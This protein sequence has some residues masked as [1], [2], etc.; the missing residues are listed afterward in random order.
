LTAP[1]RSLLGNLPR[2]TSLFLPERD[3]SYVFGGPSLLELAER[4]RAA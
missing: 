2:K 4:L 3:Y 1:D